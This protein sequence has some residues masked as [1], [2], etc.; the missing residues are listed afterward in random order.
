MSAGFPHRTSPRPDTGVTN[1]QLGVWLLIASEVMLFAGL[2]SSDVL[3]RTG[4]QDWPSDVLPVWPAVS[5][6]V[7]VLAAAWTTGRAWRVASERHTGTPRGWVAASALLLTGALASVA[8]TWQGL[9]A[10]GQGPREATVYAIFFALSG[11]FALHLVGGLLAM[12]WALWPTT[13]ESSGFVAA[14]LHGALLYQRFLA[15]VWLVL[16]LLLYVV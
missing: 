11:I 5:E 12:L 6:T 7:M 13:P 14:R 10:D 9:L 4:S 16:L 2:V 1:V 8:V 3:L 15:V